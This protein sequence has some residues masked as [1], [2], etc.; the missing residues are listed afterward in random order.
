MKKTTAILLIALLLGTGLF[1]VATEKG[2]AKIHVSS[3]VAEFSLFGVSSARLLPAAYTSIANFSKAVSA[4]ISSTVVMTQLGDQVL[5]GY[6]AA[7]NNTKVPL[8]I[9]LAATPLSNGTDSVLIH[10]TPTHYNIPK[11]ADSTFGILESSPIHIKEK[12]PGAAQRAPAGEYASTI[13]ITL[14]FGG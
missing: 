4:S 9:Y 1:A 13:R 14:T 8:N 6:V 10:V 12:T 3:L 7:L 5:V 2:P 11:A